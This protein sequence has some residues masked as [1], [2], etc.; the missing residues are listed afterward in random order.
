MSLG[1]RKH[2]FRFLTKMAFSLFKINFE[3]K[4]INLL[5]DNRNW[6]EFDQKQLCILKHNPEIIAHVVCI[7]C[8]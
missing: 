8:K 5:K 4:K 1:D 7:F 6:T 2:T 3:A